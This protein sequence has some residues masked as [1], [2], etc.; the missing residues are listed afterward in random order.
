MALFSS[1]ISGPAARVIE[2]M[3]RDITQQVIRD[4]NLPTRQDVEA[5]RRSLDDAERRIAELELALEEQASST[6]APIDSAINPPAA[7]EAPPAKRSRGRKSLRH[8]AC[9]VEGCTEPH[10]SKGFCSAHYQQWRRGN[11]RGYV[12][13]EGIIVDGP[14]RFQVNRRLS[15]KPCTVSGRVNARV[16][17]VDGVTVEATALEPA[18]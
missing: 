1:V 11:L 10:R 3:I 4:H 9:Q 12:L 14:R 6:P 13:D 16:I 5:I 15:G 7:T 17:R 2:G 18:A 8:L